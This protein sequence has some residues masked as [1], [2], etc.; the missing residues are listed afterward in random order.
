MIGAMPI[1]PF[2]SVAGNSERGFE[3]LAQHLFRASDSIGIPRRILVS[4]SEPPIALQYCFLHP[5]Q[6]FGT[7][8]DW[9]GSA[10]AVQKKG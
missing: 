4:G 8:V 2:C 5:S 6:A 3:G 7:E 9:L 1:G 10:L